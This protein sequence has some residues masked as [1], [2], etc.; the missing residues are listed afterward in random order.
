MRRNRFWHHVGLPLVQALARVDPFFAGAATAAEANLASFKPAD[1]PVRLTA[2]HDRDGS[3]TGDRSSARH[4]LS[5]GDRGDASKDQRHSSCISNINSGSGEGSGQSGQAIVLVTPEDADNAAAKEDVRE[6]IVTQGSSVAFPN[7]ASA[8]S[9]RTDVLSAA[10]SSSALSSELHALASRGTDVSNLMAILPE[11][12]AIASARSS[13]LGR[14]ERRGTEDSDEIEAGEIDD[15][16]RSLHQIARSGERG[17][18]GG[19]GG[20][21]SGGGGG[22]Y[23]RRRT[24]SGV[25][26]GSTDFV[27]GPSFRR[28]APLNVRVSSSS[29]L[30]DAEEALEGIV[31]ALERCDNG[32][33]SQSFTAGDEGSHRGSRRGSRSGR[34]TSRSGLRGEEGGPRV[35]AV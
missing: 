32:G 16:V 33:G 18:R 17:R 20:S 24:D 8:G 3:G 27:G 1:H 28:D 22:A 11:I 14:R 31:E 30:Q 2:L 12:Q 9:I 35:T 15:I 10:L 19:G 29:R 25:G 7:A 5:T 13:L 21:G 23:Q 34:R 6:A 4:R 26:T